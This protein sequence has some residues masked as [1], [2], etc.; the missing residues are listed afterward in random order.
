MI[1]NLTFWDEDKADDEQERQ[2]LAQFNAD[3]RLARDLWIFNKD[4]RICGTSKSLVDG[5]NGLKQLVPNGEVWLVYKS[6]SYVKLKAIEEKG[7]FGLTAIWTKPAM[8][9]NGLFREVVR[10]LKDFAV[11]KGLGFYASANPFDARF[12]DQLTLDLEGFEYLSDPLKRDQTARMLRSEGFIEIPLLRIHMDNV[13]PLLVR[14]VR[15]YKG[16]IP[17]M[18]LFNVE[19]EQDEE[20]DE[21][22]FEHQLN[23]IRDDLEK[24]P[25]KYDSLGDRKTSFW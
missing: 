3:A 24:D 7:W 4:F 18:F 23:R 2:T 6:S 17:R 13:E 8:R 12:F 21:S 15:D 11:E 9:G 25:E 22:C 1:N 19:D 10:L 5:E 14:I 20:F 16:L